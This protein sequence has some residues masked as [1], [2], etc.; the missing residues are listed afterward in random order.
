M[1]LLLLLL[2]C[3]W[4]F[5]IQQ[6]LANTEKTIF[7]APP[8]IPIPDVN[9]GLDNLC[10]H[11]LSPTHRALRTKLAVS[12]PTIEQPRG[13]Q[14]WFLLDGLDPA[15][16]YEVRQPTQFWLDAHT[17]TTVF[18]TPNL[19]TPLAHY[20]EEQQGH[21]PQ[22]AGSRR[23]D[24][25]VLFLQIQAAADFFTLNKTLMSDPPLVDV[26]II[27]DPYILNVFPRSLLPTA[28]YITIIAVASYFLATY[29]YTCMTQEDV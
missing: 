8:S 17:I 26:D 14:S 13:N 12:F 22:S 21:C 3:T 18:E 27:L 11:T 4:P 24:Q 23:Q 25:T 19:I 20:S 9:P 16:R 2:L 29:V 7:L 15:R 1:L 28:G 6:T 5:I 10:L